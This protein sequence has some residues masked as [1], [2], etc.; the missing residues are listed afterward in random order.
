[1]KKIFAALLLLLLLPSF[2]FALPYTGALTT[3]DGYH[4]I[5]DREGL[6]KIAQAPNE[7]YILMADIDLS[8]QAWIP[9]PF[10]GK[11][12]GN[13]HALLN[14]KIDAAG[15]DKRTT[16]DGNHKAYD[17]VFA[18]LFSVAENAKIT[19]L[20]LLGVKIDVTQEENCF[21]APLCGYALSCEISNCTVEGSVYLH[22]PSKMGGVSGLVGYG[23]GQISECKTDVTLV[24]V[25]TNRKENCEQ[26]LGGILACGYA[27][28]E[29]T[30]VRLDGYASVHGY[31]HN[32]G[33]IGMHHIHDRGVEHAGFVRECTMEGKIT[34]YEDNS[35]RRAYCKAFVG[36]LLH[37]DVTL[38][39][40]TTISFTGTET[41]DF[42]IDLL[43]HT[44]ENPQY[45]KE[46]T[47]PDCT[48]YG[49]QTYTCT[50]CGYAYKAEYSMPAHQFGNPQLVAPT[51]T[52]GGYT[53]YTC[54]LCGETKQEEETQPSHKDKVWEVIQEASYTKP[55]QMALLC[56]ECGE[57]FEQK[58]SPVLVYTR[59]IVMEER[60]LLH[61]NQK[62]M[63]PFK[64]LPENASRRDVVFSSSDESIV[65][66]MEDGSLLAKGC[67]FA[68]ITCTSVDGASQAACM[69][70]VKY[71][72]FQVILDLTHLLRG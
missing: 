17:T 40:N 15:Q 33:V 4:M 49:Y 1:M 68:A 50:Q 30:S 24:Y 59:S 2:V 65:E 52:Q 28:V 70:R 41:H 45:T 12:D 27:D 55:G 21:A 25:D 22:T 53:L 46:E 42:S 5:Y 35:D 64:V 71:A 38:K 58:E 56:P 44:C 39:D 20:S 16:I 6:E 67:G 43:P 29:K 36:E 31:V 47:L 19:N 62:V 8:D 9:I 63:L 34:F 11:L 37:K 7:K 26:F 32:G 60:L 48:H 10:Y 69:V 14:L 13:G 54:S 66:V 61:P 23:T 72:P 57:I 51:C 3:A 18:S